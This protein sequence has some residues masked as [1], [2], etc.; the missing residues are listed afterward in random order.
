MKSVTPSV[1]AI[2]LF[3]PLLPVAAITD[4]VPAQGTPESWECKWCRFEEEK[5][6]HGEIEGGAAY[7]STDSYKFGQYSGLNA[8]GFNLIGNADVHYRG[9]GARFL[10]LEITDLGL[11]SRAARIE[12]G[13]QGEFTFSIEY[14][15]LPY[16]QLNAAE[17]PFSG[18]GG[19]LLSLP[20]DWVP[21]NT[22]DQMS[23]LSESLQPEDIGTKRK[24]LGLGGT[25]IPSPE[26]NL[27]AKFNRE[28]KEG[29]K[30][31]A[32]MF[33]NDNAFAARSAILPAPVDYV[34]EQL[35]A[36]ATYNTR[37]WQAHIG[38]YGSFFKNENK[39]LAWR[40]P[41]SN[42]P[43]DA[44][45]GQMALEP[46]N[47]FHQIFF[48]GGYQFLRRTRGTAHVAWGRMLQNESFLPYTT[49]GSL[50]SSS[51]PRNSL[52][53][54]VDTLAIKL[55]LTSTPIDKLR[56][57]ANFNFTDYDN[58]TDKATYDYVIA[59]STP[60]LISR[61]N[62]PYSYEKGLLE[63]SG[64]YRLPKQTKVLAGFDYESFDRTFQER[65]NTREATAWGGVRVRPHEELEA[66]LKYTYAE[67]DGGAYEEVPEISPPENALLRKYNMA[68]R[69]RSKAHAYVSY[70][71][72]ELVTFGLS[73]DYATDDYSNSILGLTDG[74]ETSVTLDASYVPREDL[75]LYAFYTRDNIDTKQVGSQTFS[76]P[77][78][79]ADGT[80]RI[81]TAGLGVKYTVIED[82]LDLGADYTYSQANG[83][84]DV[85]S[86]IIDLTPLPDLKT[87]LHQLKLYA[88]YRL[89]E[90]LS[91]RL[92]YIYEDYEQSDFT[93]DGVDPDSIRTVLSLGGE[94]SNYSAHLM[95]ISLRYRF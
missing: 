43:S 91:L 72:H 80:D 75:S 65:S 60:S 52:D 67:R 47:S 5:G 26:W 94:D 18:A 84:I 83:A 61:T 19:N 45:F 77:D 23:T 63:L 20:D 37:K 86:S 55:G 57:K 7:L 28:T 13:K 38:Y 25:F 17:T 30:T 56:L 95:G 81:N 2:A 92:D 89:K 64:S 12:G 41:F 51:L 78:W 88:D 76:T 69:K 68:D 46:D 66:T 70:M 36:G 31:L 11:D 16:L 74:E 50:T 39:S 10:D 71:P 82:K 4:E 44:N 59:D 34:T 22:T 62:Q 87:R 33:G 35:E 29:T 73:M 85:H 3:L 49:N 53:G 21:A 14:D 6:G 27:Y 79:F 54:R 90:K 40:N 93:T 8:K 32:G 58:K 1:L 24:N 9:A 15:E 42:P 48:S